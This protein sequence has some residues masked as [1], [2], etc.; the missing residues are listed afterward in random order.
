M[1]EIEKLLKE[2]SELLGRGV[3]VVK[4]EKG[5][6][7]VLFMSLTSPPP[8]C[9]DTQEEALRRFIMW[10][11]QSFRDPDQIIEGD[12]LHDTGIDDIS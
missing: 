6:Y 7:I 12:L 2:A 8:P 5:K 4:T 11:K 10:Y 3:E 9:A 1:T